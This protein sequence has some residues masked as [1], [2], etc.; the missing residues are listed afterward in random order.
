MHARTHARL[1]FHFCRRLVS[2]CDFNGWECYPAV[3]AAA[4]SRFR[5]VQV[6]NSARQGAGGRHSEA[7]EGLPETADAFDSDSDDG[8]TLLRMRPEEGKVVIHFH[9]VV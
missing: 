2:N 4:G 1:E 9:L 8:L 3:A 6:Q 7:S 5:A